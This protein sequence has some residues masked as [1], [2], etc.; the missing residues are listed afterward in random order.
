[1]TEAGQRYL[2]TCGPVIAE[3]DHAALAARCQAHAP[4]GLL[5]V[6]IAPSAALVES[7]LP[8][9]AELRERHPALRFD[10]VVGLQHADVVNEEVDVA[11]R[12]WRPVGSG[13]VGRLLRPSFFSFAA[14]PDYLRRKGTPRTLAEL[15]G[16]DLATYGDLGG[17][18]FD[19]V[20]DP[21][22]NR[23]PLPKPPWLRT[24]SLDLL[25]Q[26]VVA[27]VGVGLIETNCARRQIERGALVDVL[28]NYRL[29]TKDEGI[30]AVFASRRR[31]DPKVRAFVDLLVD[32]RDQLFR[33]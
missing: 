25:E 33:G 17:F 27:G 2:A 1:M 22:G 13:V 9:M 10:L 28:P 16:H 11:V 23:H 19:H 29:G 18:W 20:F 31:L 15:S 3:L 24:T 8:L 30:Y 26:V 12:G 14:A 4:A 5:R 21:D 32:R 6:A 7:L